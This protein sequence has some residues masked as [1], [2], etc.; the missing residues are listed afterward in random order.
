MTIDS[1]KD[2]PE[3]DEEKLLQAASNQPVSVGLCGSERSFQ[4]YSK[5]NSLYMIVI[6]LS[7]LI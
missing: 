2:V 3:S 1:Y 5:V 7:H 4:H 6:Q